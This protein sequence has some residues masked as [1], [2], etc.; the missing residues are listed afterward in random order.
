[1]KPRVCERVVEIPVGE[2]KA[3][4]LPGEVKLADIV[5]GTKKLGPCVK[6]LMRPFV[7]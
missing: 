3:T 6:M 5:P 4:E 7:P 1:M 2:S